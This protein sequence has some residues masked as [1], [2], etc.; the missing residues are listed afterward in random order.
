[1]FKMTRSAAG[2][3]A[4]GQ[5]SQRQGWEESGVHGCLVVSVWWLSSL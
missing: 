5:N 2:S 3:E 1:M 4:G